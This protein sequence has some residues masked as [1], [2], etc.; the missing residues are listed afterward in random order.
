[1]KLYSKAK[2]CGH[3]THSVHSEHCVC[4]TDCTLA[5]SISHFL[6]LFLPPAHTHSAQPAHT[7][8]CRYSGV[9]LSV[10][11]GERESV[12][13]C[14]HLC[15]CIWREVVSKTMR[16]RQLCVLFSDVCVL[17]FDGW[18]DGFVTI[19]SYIIHKHTH[20]HTCIY[21]PHWKNTVYKTFHCAVLFTFIQ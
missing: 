12:Y 5:L 3:P 10:R 1:M 2:H 16:L 15:L 20:T 6:F 7:K 14:V 8:L 19:H 17:L 4:S 21:S 18:M 13:F 9:C 11:R